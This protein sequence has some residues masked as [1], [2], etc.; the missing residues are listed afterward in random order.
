MNKIFLL[1][2]KKVFLKRK[3]FLLKRKKILLQR[4]FSGGRTQKKGG[5]MALLFPCANI[6]RKYFISKSAF[7]VIFTSVNILIL[8][9]AIQT[10]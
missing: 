10:L 2:K 6:L 5:S 4:T 1:K 9:F 8:Q 7:Y 3:K